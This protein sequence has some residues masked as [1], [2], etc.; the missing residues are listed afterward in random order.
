MSARKEKKARLREAKALEAQTQ[1]RKKGSLLFRR[2]ITL[3]ALAGGLALAAVTLFNTNRE[4]RLTFINKAGFPLDSIKVEFPGGSKSFESLA[5]DDKISIRLVP[6][7]PI[8]PE[9]ANKPL[10]IEINKSGSAPL[11]FRSW[12]GNKDPKLHQIFAATS[13]PDGRLEVMPVVGA[14]NGTRFSFRALLRSIGIGR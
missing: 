2:R 10:V 1:Q 7:K 12:A 9:D 5:P 4:A 6:D 13:Q 3:V 11:K 8:P 14:E